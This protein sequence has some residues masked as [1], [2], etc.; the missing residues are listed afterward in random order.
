[1]FDFRNA[2][3]EQKRAITT[4]EGPVLITAGPGT[5]KTFTLVKRALYLIQEKGVKPEQIMLVTFTEKA[6]KELVTRMTNEME[7]MGIRANLN[8]MY[9]G[10]FHSICLRIIKENVDFTRLKKNYRMLDGFDQIYTIYQNIFKFSTLEGFGEVV[11]D[12]NWWG[13]AKAIAGLVNPLS[14]ELV[15]ADKMMKDKD[16]KMATLGNILKTYKKMLSDENMLDF[17]A[18]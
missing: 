6:A 18:I 4:T 11:P 3:K 14:E 17:A 1:M 16:P 13:Q 10:T 9:V 2:N 12:K 7:K 5:G 8:E 15:D